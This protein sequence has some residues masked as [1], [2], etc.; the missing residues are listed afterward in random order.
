MSQ[1]R[2][3]FLMVLHVHKELT[4]QL[5]LI[6]VANE[7]VSNKSTEHRLSIFGKFTERDTVGVSVCP[8]CGKVSSCSTCCK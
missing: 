3:N 7:F 8:N 2:L 4:D 6:E 5:H 1:V